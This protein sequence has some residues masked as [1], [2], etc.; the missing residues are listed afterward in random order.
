MTAVMTKDLGVRQ[1][2]AMDSLKFHPGPILVRPAGGPPLKQPSSFGHPTPYAYDKGSMMVS[3]RAQVCQDH[4]QLMPLHDAQLCIEVAS[5]ADKTRM[6]V[7]SFRPNHNIHVNSL[8]RV[9]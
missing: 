4:G 1:G 5:S 3:F 7:L 9:R 8:E 6:V 2:V